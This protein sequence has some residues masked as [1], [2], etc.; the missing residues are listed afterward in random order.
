MTKDPKNDSQELEAYRK[1]MVGLAYRMVGTV[2][3]AEDIVQDALVKWLKAERGMIASP[4]A[5]LSRVTTR[6]AL[7]YLK[8]ARVSREAYVG[9]WLPEPYV[10]PSE[11]P[12]SILEIDESV[13]MA[14]L[15]LLEKLEPVERAAFILHDVFRYRHAEIAQVLGQTTI[16]SRQLVSR[17]R[18]KIKSEKIS[19]KTDPDEWLKLTEAF[20]GAVKNGNMDELHS[21]LSPQV[22]LYA[23]GG[24][25]AAAA[26]RPIHGIDPVTE[27][28]LSV[29]Y[30]TITK[31]ESRLSIVRYNGGPGIVAT[32]DGKIVTAYNVQIV[33]G[34]IANIYAIRNPDKLARM[35]EMD[36]R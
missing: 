9:P 10:E 29:I 2:D 16:N 35:Q 30:P 8:S 31:T 1:K 23:D 20:L 13:S 11:T 27:F 33:E 19:R 14:L 17:A 26:S 24:G 5:W 28:I 15:A 22:A 36:L 21:I 34:K 7:D 4:I 3:A 18:K 25:K 12:E 32:I 6:L